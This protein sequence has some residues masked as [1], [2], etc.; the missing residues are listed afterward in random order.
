M[1]MVEIEKGSTRAKIH[2]D[3]NSPYKSYIKDVTRGLLTDYVF[4]H[5]IRRNVVGPVRKRDVLILR[6]TEIEA[7]KIKTKVTKGAYS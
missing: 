3:V 6:E 4:D 5:Q 1:G 7:R 2:I